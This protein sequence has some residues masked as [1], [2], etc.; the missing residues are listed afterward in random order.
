MV[1]V[2]ESENLKNEKFDNFDD[3]TESY[4]RP[5]KF[6]RFFNFLFCRCDLNKETLEAPP[7]SFIDLFRFGSKNDKIAVTIAIIC[8]TFA[9][10][11]YNFPFFVGGKIATALILYGQEPGNEKILSMG[12]PWVGVNLFLAF[13]VFILSYFQTYLLKRSCTNIITNLRIKF[14]ESLLRQDAVWMDQQKFGVLNA[15]LTESID[16]IR[17]GIGEKVALVV[18]GISSLV[19]CILFSIYIDWKSFLIVFGCAPI[20]VF[21]MSFMA[22]KVYKYFFDFFQRL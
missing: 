9:G 15:Q 22:K 21:F 10:A 11:L 7:V 19:G 3:E 1:K 12:L 5:S 2:F 16:V 13:A 18:R 17:D 14:I 8:G 6:E 4:L 20:S